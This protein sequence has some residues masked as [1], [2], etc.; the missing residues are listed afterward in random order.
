MAP[1]DRQHETYAAMAVQ[2]EQMAARA[3]TQELA[4]GYRLI[5]EGYRVLARDTA[6]RRDAFSY[7]PPTPP[8]ASPGSDPGP[9]DTDATGR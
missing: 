1:T 5:A 4:E 3:R 9:P 6:I 7:L 2:F 8:F